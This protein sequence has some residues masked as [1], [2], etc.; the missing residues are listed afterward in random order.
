V[1][2]TTGD[3]RLVNS[4]VAAIRGVTAGRIISSGSGGTKIRLGVS[5]EF[6]QAV[7]AARKRVS[8]LQNEISD[9][10]QVLGG[11]REELA[12]AEADLRGLIA[13]LKDPAQKGNREGLLGQVDMIKPLRE[14][15]KEGLANGQARLDEMMYELQRTQEKLEEMEV[16]MP[17]GSVWLDVRQGA[18]ATTEIRA[19][20][21][22]LVLQAK[23]GAFSARELV[24]KD[25]KTGQN[26]PAIQMGN[27]RSGV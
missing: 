9:L 3:G 6:E 22:S 23:E 16:V 19:P 5:A 17:A 25:K 7:Y 8:H 1:V 13:A 27:L 26:K 21:S 24:V 18:D 2:L 10:A 14:T 11:Q 20:R 12:G 15:L 4:R